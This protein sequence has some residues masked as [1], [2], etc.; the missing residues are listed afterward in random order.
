MQT[1]RRKRFFKR[2]LII[3]C[4][5]F[6]L[7][8]MVAF[9]HA[10]KFTHFV[11]RE[12]VKTADPVKMSKAQKIKTLFFG[13][14]NP[15]PTNKIFPSGEYETIRLK[16][17]KEIECW[18]IRQPRSIGT[19]VIFHGYAGEKSSMLDKAEAFLELG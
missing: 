15:R 1:S 16:S 4:I 11:S 19:V 13:V 2:T 8:N 6:F 18:Y 17:N 3:V 9:F 7:A 12:T 5:L 14:N 10:Y